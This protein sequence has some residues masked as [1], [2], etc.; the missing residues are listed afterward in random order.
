MVYA[1]AFAEEDILSISTRLFPKVST[2]HVQQVVRSV[3]ALNACM[4]GTGNSSMSMQSCEFNL[5]DVLRWVHLLNSKSSLFSRAVPSELEAPIILNRLRSEGD[6]RRAGQAIRSLCDVKASFHNYFLNADPSS[7]Q[8]GYGYLNK[9]EVSSFLPVSQARHVPRLIESVFIAIQENWPCLMVGAPESSSLIRNLA[10]T[11]GARVSTISLSADV[12]A[13][14]LVGGYEQVDHQRYVAKF[15]TTLRETL[16]DYLS[17]MLLSDPGLEDGLSEFGVLL[18]GTFPDLKFTSETIRRLA[19]KDPHLFQPLLDSCL[20]IIQQSS[21]DSRARFEWVDSIVIEAMQQGHWL[22]LENANLCSSSVLDRLN[23]LL[24]PGGTLSVHEH[25]SADGSPHVVVPHAAFRVFL[26]IDPRHGEPS[27]AMRNRCLELYIPEDHEKE[28][29]KLTLFDGDYQTSRFRNVD[30]FDWG[31]MSDE[32]SLYMLQLCVDHLAPSDLE[33]LEAWQKEMSNG[34]VNLTPKMKRMLGWAS[35]VFRLMANDSIIIRTIERL[36]MSMVSAMHVG[37]SLI[38]TIEA[39]P[40]NPLNNSPLVSQLR[41]TGSMNKALWIA[42]FLDCQFALA[43]LQD[44]LEM[45]GQANNPGWRT[46]TNRLERSILESRSRAFSKDSTIHLHWF[47]LNLL[48]TIESWSKSRFSSNYEVEEYPRAVVDYVV[49]LFEVSKS[50]PFDES[51]FQAYLRLGRALAHSLQKKLSLAEIGQFL[52]SGLGKFDPMWALTTGLSMQ[53]L[54]ASFRPTTPPNVIDLKRIL[55]L[56]AVADKFD[57]DAWRSDSTMQSIL[58][59]RT[60]LDKALKQL[61]SSQTPIFDDIHAQ[62]PD[63]FRHMLQLAAIANE[64][65]VIADDRTKPYLCNEFESL[66]QY[67]YSYGV[68]N[69]PENQVALDLLSGRSTKDAGGLPDSLASTIL[70]SSLRNC[71]GIDTESCQLSALKGTLPLNIVRKCSQMPEIPLR[72]LSRLNEELSLF[73]NQVANATE[74]LDVDQRIALRNLLS[75]LLYQILEAHNNV[76]EPESL[77]EWA[78]FLR[79]PKHAET[80]KSLVMC[81]S[82]ET[83]GANP[84]LPASFKKIA[85]QYFHS[86][87]SY[88]RED[89]EGKHEPTL[90]ADSAW[91][92]IFIGSLK[93]YVPNALNDPAMMPLVEAE[94][95]AKRKRE[96]SIQLSALEA[97][98]QKVN[99]SQSSLRCEIVRQRL[100]D[101]GEQRSTPSMARPLIPR[102]KE[103]QEEFRRVIEFIILPCE[104]ILIGSSRDDAELHIILSNIGRFISRLTDGYREYQDL[105]GPLVGLLRGLAVGLTLRLMKFSSSRPSSE[106]TLPFNSN[107]TVLGLNIREPPLSIRT[108]SSVSGSEP[109]DRGTMLLEYLVLEKSTLGYLESDSVQ[110][111]TEVLHSF[112][113]SWKRKLQAEQAQLAS[114]SSLYHYKGES[115]A[116]FDDRKDLDSLFP[117]TIDYRAPDQQIES[118]IQESPQTFAQTASLLHWRLFASDFQD[119]KPVIS[120]AREVVSRINTWDLSQTACSSAQAVGL[121]PVML[122]AMDEAHNSILTDGENVKSNFYHE[123]NV[124]EVKELVSFLRKLRARV[125]TIQTSWPEHETLKDILKTAEE[126]LDVKLSA[127]LVS[128]VPQTEKLLTFVDEWQQRASKD[129]TREFSLQSFYDDLTK[130]LISWRRLELSAWAIL[131]DNEDKNYVKEAQSWWFVAYE[132]IF[133]PFWESVGSDYDPQDYLEDLVA[134]LQKF[135]RNAP[136]GQFEARLRMLQMFHRHA[137]YLVQSVPIFR[138]VSD[139]LA[140]TLGYFKRWSLQVRARISAH[141]GLVNGKLKE[142]LFLASL[143]DTTI[144]ALRASARKSHYHLLKIV[145]QYRELLG[146]ES[147]SLFQEPVSEDYAK[148]YLDNKLHRKPPKSFDD[149]ALQVCRH[150]FPAWLQG[151]RF[152]EDPM[153]TAASMSHLAVMPPKKLNSQSHVSSFRVNLLEAIQS[154]QHET[155]REL[156]P[157][158]KSQVKHLK[159]RKRNLLADTLKQIRQL[160]IRTNLDSKTLENQATTEKILSSL[161]FNPELSDS[162]QQLY[163]VVDEMSVARQTSKQHSQDLTSSEISR[164]LGLLEGLLC[165]LIK[166]RQGLGEAFLELQSLE[167]STSSL[168]LLWNPAEYEVKPRDNKSP[169]RDQYSQRFRWLETIINGTQFI[170]KKLERMG[171]NDFSPL[172]NSL[173]QKLDKGIKLRHLVEALPPVPRGLATSVEANGLSEVNEFLTAFNADILQWTI[174]FPKAKFILK[175]LQPWLNIEAKI[176][177]PREFTPAN[178]SVNWEGL[179][180]ENSATN[181]P[182]EVDELEVF[183]TVDRMLVG[184][185]SLKK[186]FEQLPESSEYAGWLVQEE[187]I[188]HKATRSLRPREIAIQ[189]NEH[190]LSRMPTLQS[191][192]LNSACALCAVIFPITQ[193]YRSSFCAILERRVASYSTLC[194]LA[195][196]LSRTFNQ[197]AAQGFCSPQDTS[198]EQAKSGKMEEGVGLGDGE[199]AE[200]ISKDIRE[201][202]DLSGAAQ[203][204]QLEK[205]KDN[206]KTEGHDDAIDVEDEELADGMEDAAEDSATD[207]GSGQDQDS[208]EEEMTDEVGEVDDF[209]SAA[210]DEKIWEGAARDARSE[211]EDRKT[212]GEKSGEVSAQIE[213]DEGSQVSDGEGNEDHGNENSEQFPQTE[214]EPLGSNVEEVEEL[215]LPEDA[216]IDGKPSPKDLTDDEDIDNMSD[217]DTQD[218]ESLGSNDLGEEDTEMHE[219]GESAQDENTPDQEKKGHDETA[220]AQPSSADQEDLNTLDDKRPVEDLDADMAE[221]DDMQADQLNGSDFQREEQEVSN[222][223]STKYSQNEGKSSRDVPMP[224]IPQDPQELEE[225]EG[226]GDRRQSLDVTQNERDPTSDVEQQPFRKLGE[227]LE[228]WHRA[229]RAIRN[230]TDEQTHNSHEEQE[231]SSG[232]EFEHLKDKNDK[233]DAQALDAATEEEA[234]A[235]NQNQLEADEFAEAIEHSENDRQTPY[236]EAMDVDHELES[237]EEE[238]DTDQ[239]DVEA[240]TN[241]ENPRDGSGRPLNIL[242]SEEEEEVSLDNIDSELSEVQLNPENSL[243]RSVEEARRLWSTCERNTRELS[244]SLTEQ[245]RLILAPTQAT[246]MRG[247]FR[248]G[249]RL[250]IKRIIPYIASQYKRDKIWMRRS[251]PSKRNYQVMIAVDDSKSM[252]E[253]GSG[254]LAFESLALLSRSLGMLEVGQLCIASFGDNF[255]VAHPFEQEFSTESAIHVM[256]HFRFQQKSTKITTLLRD[257]LDV[258]RQARARQTSSGADT[259]Q[260]QLIVSDG[261]CEDHESIRRLVRQAHKE[262]IIV[263][264]IIV[265][266]S[267]HSIINMT[268]AEFENVNGEMKLKVKQYLADFPFTY[269]LVVRDITGLPNVLSKALSQWFSEISD[270]A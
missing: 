141:R 42:D 198:G 203:G 79:D 168:N 109:C 16:K 207:D 127:P 202:E 186:A 36:Y 146:Q 15:S 170:I 192:A 58:V 174:E 236:P 128:I 117:N 137:E 108:Q 59:L 242:N 53:L 24:E 247:D 51:K 172:E 267:K 5:R 28:A 152:L 212:N 126:L 80:P 13:T 208:E 100:S 219:P 262:R 253:S 92:N 84:G 118:K 39:Q 142:T 166:Q 11:Y 147:H 210:V 193:Q 190:L 48:E 164:S 175:Y 83:S 99:G 245:L 85:S 232:I 249:K 124:R 89:T 110:K 240:F 153:E 215:G 181:H 87:L 138:Q 178:V 61:K 237:A 8:C 56:E 177:L 40:L 98:E 194:E 213:Q 234:K 258:F 140:N 78:H 225:G 204:P 19:E 64:S 3:S 171:G 134:E 57:L 44:Q 270:T 211:K 157:E 122:L 257:S 81:Q 160:G 179:N 10:V 227:A 123:S 180:G 165:H 12:D 47:F 196:L 221:S 135:V 182:M 169:N 176:D 162:D 250:N 82:S 72:Y 97:F 231:L 252:A 75:D 155:P 115:E 220:T 112:F 131:L 114:R 54:W 161:P 255:Q 21:I 216:L 266:T 14:E 191:D 235:L 187:K 230:P 113:K 167:E 30:L 143:K 145:R 222:G 71:T 90:S 224:D 233:A 35:R 226:K 88:F 29:G 173:Q 144:S 184:I 94:R 103:L 1:D 263:I 154:L 93:L 86:A 52:Q 129:P 27:R 69:S 49:D 95:W 46:T 43:H 37:Q 246:K 50:E 33:L 268:S 68:P 185:Q 4:A 121:A 116:V 60:S 260:L 132:A 73:T 218:D 34:L 66:R 133:S 102:M 38:H 91:I 105:T 77:Q 136:L 120:F 62:E 67:M 9:R 111:A 264:I 130:L 151:A 31:S 101:L 74:A 106:I 150:S 119:Q 228:R 229:N 139:V 201:D 209:D 217:M 156:T 65:L 104:R 269:Y 22:V 251:V 32:E 18:S 20:Y 248:T 125:R 200:D 239:T 107:L 265:D 244:T 163:M 6:V 195:L 96:L 55:D 183:K 189:I 158:N 241:E 76:I 199:G 238:L 7:L 148:S 17:K 256:Q 70:L 261:V 206:E 2:E 243:H 149:K 214:A 63:E 197:L 159:A 205:D 23:A 45:L 223:A 188:L 25:R 259:W 41:K 26:T 254:K